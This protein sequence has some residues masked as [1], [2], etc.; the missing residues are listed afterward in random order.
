MSNFNFREALEQN[1]VRQMENILYHQGW[2]RCWVPVDACVLA[3]SRGHEQ[4]LYWLRQQGCVWEPSLIVEAA[5]KAGHRHIID[6][7]LNEGD[8]VIVRASDRLGAILAQM[9]KV[10]VIFV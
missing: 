9:S 7:M 8:A 2:S 6:R 3:A 1:D 5:R 10:A 4:A